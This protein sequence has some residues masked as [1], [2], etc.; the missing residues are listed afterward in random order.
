MGTPV[1]NSLGVAK[2]S[3]PLRMTRVGKEKQVTGEEEGFAEVAG[4]DLVRVADSGEV[5]AGVPAQQKIDVRRYLIEL[6][7]S[8]G[9]VEKW[10]KE[11]GDAGGV[12]LELLAAGF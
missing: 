9:T 12:H 10:A 11:G 4:N 5:G 6:G 8:E 2:Q 1:R 7:G 3:A